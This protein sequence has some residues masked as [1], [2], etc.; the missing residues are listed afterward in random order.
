MSAESLRPVPCRDPIASIESCLKISLF[1]LCLSA[2]FRPLSARHLCGGA[3]FGLF[4]ANAYYGI[5]CS[6]LC[7]E[8]GESQIRAAVAG[9]VAAFFAF[10]TAAMI[11]RPTLAV[12]EV[13]A[14]TGIATAVGWLAGI[15]ETE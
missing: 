13:A 9:P 1:T 7:G 11:A 10:S 5:R 15:A 14:A 3:F 8:S 6:L 2:A 4:G 12:K